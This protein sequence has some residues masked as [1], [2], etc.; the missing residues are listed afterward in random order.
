MK[1]ALPLQFLPPVAATLGVNAVP[2]LGWLRETWSAET[3]MIL[4]YLETVAVMVLVGLLVRLA[5]PAAD[6][7]GRPQA[8]RRNKLARDYW[9]VIGGFALVIG[10]FIAAILLLF[11]GVVVPWP[12]VGWAMGVIV[13]LQVFA[14][15]WE[16]WQLRPLDIADAEMLIN[17]DIGRIAVLH[18]GVLAGSFLMVVRAEWF[19]WPFIALK[20]LVD[21]ATVIDPALSRL[22]GRASIDR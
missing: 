22:R 6:E 18:L 3:V 9:I 13:A 19:V 1:T 4:Y 15:S 16:A 7:T 14:Y 10:V 2:V 5:V 20:T 12:A 17:R 11:R 8:A 21:I